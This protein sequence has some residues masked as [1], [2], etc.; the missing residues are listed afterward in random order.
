M[1]EIDKVNDVVDGFSLYGV[2]YLHTVLEEVH[3]LLVLLHECSGINVPHPADSF[4]DGYGWLAGIHQ[5]EAVGKLRLIERHLV[6]PLHLRAI[7]ML[8]AQRLKQVKYCIL[9]TSFV[10]YAHMIRFCLSIV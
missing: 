3:E 8:V 10:K 2:R 4:F 1:L 9:V 6:I 5:H 7:D